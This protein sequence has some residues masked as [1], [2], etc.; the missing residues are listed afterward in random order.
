MRDLFSGFGTIDTCLSQRDNRTAGFMHRPVLSITSL[1]ME[2]KRMKNLLSIMAI[3]TAVSMLASCSLSGWL[4]Y[5][6]T[7]GHF[8][9]QY[10]SGS[11]VE[12][13]T[14]LTARIQLPIVEGTNL[15]EKFVDVFVEQGAI[16]CLGPYSSWNQNPPVEPATSTQTINGVYW[17]IEEG[18]EGAAGSI[19]EWTSYSTYGID[20]CVTLTFVLHSHP[21]ELIEPVPPEFDKSEESLV[22]PLIVATFQ[23]LFPT[24]TPLDATYTPT[25][26]NTW[27]PTP[28]PYFY[29]VPKFNAYCRSGPDI[30]F[31]SITLAMQD[32]SY[33]IDGR[34]QEN[35]WLYIMISPEVG[36]WVPLEDGEP[37]GDTEQVRVLNKIP[38]PTFTPI[39]FDCGQFT[40]PQSCSQHSACTWNRLVTPSV[41]QNK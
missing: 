26:A 36:C 2:E 6:N 35:T 40:D 19:Y 29:F 4:T 14:P 5:T 22:F 1:W 11:T 3:F 41:C 25:P 37:S 21:P 30:I 10:P 8:E 31:G 32:Q 38:T 39:S 17:V 9:F 24:P 20:Y 13:D 33:P 34:N 27:T 15:T 28:A 23:W 12:T 7:T 16:P 18:S